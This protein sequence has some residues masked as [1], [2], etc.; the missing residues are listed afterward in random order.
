M[1]GSIYK[2]TNKITNMSYIGQSLYPEQRRK[3]HENCLAKDKFHTALRYYGI[4]NFEYSIIESNIPE[5]KLDERERY[6]IKYYDSYYNGYNSSLGGEQL[7]MKLPIKSKKELGLFAGGQVM[8]GYDINDKKEYIINKE[9]AKIVKLVFEKYSAGKP[10]NQIMKDL[11]ISNV[12]TIRNILNR[13]CYYD[14]TRPKIISKSLFDKAKLMRT[15]FKTHNTK[16]Q[17]ILKGI[18]YD[19]DNNR[20]TT[21]SGR[22]RFISKK[23]NKSI[24][25]L[26]CDILL[27]YINYDYDKIIANRVERYIVKFDIYNKNKYIES[28][29]IHTYNNKR[30]V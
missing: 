11:D 10:M 3:G 1:T 7:R 23:N 14:G 8:F 28:I 19:N 13:H 4:I 2:Y 12:G 27:S 17:H 22:R 29:K 24:K 16:N 25:F 26:T 5:E 21:N 20:M 15:R 9:Q 18:L 6:W 30:V